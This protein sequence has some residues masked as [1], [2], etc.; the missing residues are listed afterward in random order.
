MEERIDEIRINN[1]YASRLGSDY[2]E[3]FDKKDP[4]TP[5]VRKNIMRTDAYLK[6]FIKQFSEEGN[7]PTLYPPNCR[8]IKTY[9]NGP[10]VVVVEEPPAMRSIRVRMDMSR[11][12]ESLKNKKQWELFGYEN[13]FKENK[14]PYTFM[15][16]IPYVIHVLQFNGTAFNRGKVY[17]RPKPLLGMSDVLYRPPLLNTSGNMGVCYG[18]AVYKGPKSGIAK[19][20]E[21]AQKV[22]WAAEFNPDYIE[23]YNEYSET[24]GLCDYFTWQYY[25]QQNPMFVYTADWILYHKPID[26]VI[27]NIEHNNRLDRAMIGYKTFTD[28]FSSP[29]VSDKKVKVGSRKAERR[30]VYDVCNGWYPER[31]LP[32]FIGDPLPYSK[33]RIAYLDSFIG[34]EGYSDPKYVR[35]LVDNKRPVLKLN[36]KV[37]EFFASKI[38]ELR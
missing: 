24:A 27:R 10:T 18:D 35:L 20:A 16:A 9:P 22:F 29:T 8:M 3:I 4:S 37:K 33:D 13:F 26:E 21:H 23:N 11:D 28:I 12:S 25:S 17:F 32:T 19:E 14:K 15:L 36:K 6:K 1:G 38:K 2:G 30:L 5:A 7:V 31:D 34:I